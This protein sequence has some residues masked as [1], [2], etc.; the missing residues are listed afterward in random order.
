MKIRILN[1][2]TNPLPEYKTKGSA[3]MDLLSNNEAE[4]ILKPMER[5]LVP[6]GLFVEIPNGYE[7]QVRARSGLSIKNGITLVNAVGTIDSDYRGELKV[8][9]INLGHED[10][11][12][13]RGD[14]IAQLIV[15]KYEQVIW[16]DSDSVDETDRGHGGFGSTGV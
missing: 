1:K 9:V 8:P 16:E 15:T 7:G 14:R 3:G 11:T 6:T 4:I 10:F 12:I 13:K 5:T 2:S